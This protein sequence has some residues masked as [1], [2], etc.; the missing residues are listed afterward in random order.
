MS[1][2]LLANLKPIRVLIINITPTTLRKKISNIKMSHINYHKR[3]D[4][5]LISM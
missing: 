1:R 4:L 3:G 5:K 2:Y